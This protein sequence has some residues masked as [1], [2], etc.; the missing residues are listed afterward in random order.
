M[1]TNM[2]VFIELLQ[3][4]FRSGLPA[5]LLAIGIFLT[6]KILDFADM[7]AEG[8]F[9]VSGAVCAVCIIKGMSPIIAT[10]LGVAAGGACGF[11][12]GFLNRVLKI[13]KLLSGII[14]M[15]AAG[16]VALLI[17]GVT[18]GDSLFKASVSLSGKDTIFSILD[19]AIFKGWNMVIMMLAVVIIAFL[20]IYFFFGTEYGMAIRA[21][22]MNENMAK[23]QGINTTIS[24]IACVAISNAIIGLAGALYAQSEKGMYATSATGYLIVGLASILIG[25]AVFGNRSFIN[26]L[27]SVCLGSLLYF[28]IVNVATFIFNMPTELNKILYAVL[29]TFALCIPSIK[30]LFKFKRKKFPDLPSKKD[31]L[32]VEETISENADK[33]E[34]D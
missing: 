32:F 15:T 22:G 11:V 21:T 4:I 9:L 27:V 20:I 17:F 10:L 33:V 18:S 6:F 3:L 30:K 7:T 12:T 8:S 23:A 16:S 2:D 24:T 31:I 25:E 14:T 34:A 5:C 13:P 28:T 26:S 19:P 29:I 1:L